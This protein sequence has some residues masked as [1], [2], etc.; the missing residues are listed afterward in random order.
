MDHCV[1]CGE[2]IREDDPWRYINGAG[3]STLGENGDL[4]R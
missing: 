1:I 4:W 2:E 3:E